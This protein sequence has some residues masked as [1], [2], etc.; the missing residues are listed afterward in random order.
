M[1]RGQI[2][3]EHFA[4]LNN[5]SGPERD[6]NV[7]SERR[8]A[9]FSRARCDHSKRNRRACTKL[10]C[11]MLAVAAT[12]IVQPT[13]ALASGWIVV[14]PALTPHLPV[15]SPPHSTTGAIPPSPPGH[16]LLK[17]GVSV[18]L[19]LQSE[20]VKVDINGPV[21]RTYI[22]QVF[23]NDTDRNLAGTYLFPL[24]E[25]ATFSSFS[26]QIDGKPVEGK[27]LEAQDA[28]N[29]YE[30][31]AR[32]M[33]DPGLLE[34]ADYK[35]VRARV[36]PIPPH[37]TKK[38]E[39]EYTQALKAE[40]GLFKYNFPLKADHNSEPAEAINVDMKL[41][42]PQGLRT[43]W[44]PTYTINS[45]RESDNRATI[46][47]SGKNVLPD[48][49]FLLYYSTS[50]KEMTADLMVQ[51]RKD[52]NGYF[53]LSMA[54]PMQSKIST[55]KDIVLVADTSGS[56]GGE[57][58]EQCKRALNFIVN[59]LGKTDRFGIVQFNT[60]V[61]QFRSD[62]V[63]ANDENK[64]A[65]AS[66]INNL[67]ARGG[68]N[69]SGALANAGDLLKTQSERP[70]YV[71]LMTDGEPTVGETNEAQLVQQAH[72]N[73]DIRLFDFGV[74]YDVNTRLLNALAEDHHGTAQYVEPDESLETALSSFY[75]KVKNPVLTDVSIK[76]EGVEVKN[77][78]PKEV[79]DIF[80]GTQVLLIGEYKTSGDAK[81]RITGKLNGQSK[82]YVFP[83]SFPA[84]ESGHSYLARLWAMRRI[85]YLTD[86][87]KSNGENREVI[88]EIVALSKKYGIISQYTSFLATDPAEGH[89]AARLV[90][91]VP[92]SAMMVSPVLPGNST[93]AMGAPDRAMA[94]ASADVDFGPYMAGLQR[95]IK[96]VW[97]P[98]KG[99]ES[100]QVV[101][102]FKLDRAGHVSD[103]RITRSSGVNIADQAA[104]RAVR[105]SVLRP[106]PSEASSPVDIQFTFDYNILSGRS[107][108]RAPAA[109]PVGKDAVL[110]AKDTT[111]LKNK[112]DIASAE[113]TPTTMRAVE[114][115]TFYLVD[116][117][118]TDSEYKKDEKLEQI[119]F[120]SEHYFNLVASDAQ[121]RKYFA[122]APQVIVVYKGHC[123]R[124]SATSA[125]ESA[126]HD[127]KA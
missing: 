16:P 33:I 59:S 64:K 101:V 41:A 34:Y 24:G 74:G 32:Q 77:V 96:H 43:I 68:T 2:Q 25:D 53:L 56:M 17:A 12:Y 80:A 105:D 60:D 62:L 48:K 78:Y 44:S 81:V 42:S 19:H 51:K 102:T 65:A 5:I 72:W 28:R 57:K 21:A 117:Y 121:L 119:D 35:T 70:A 89:G 49:D 109:S 13:S 50:D 111:L 11:L 126:A 14:D 8:L 87:A 85:G 36:F 58:I 115:K 125:I 10:A 112:E 90:S 107:S 91:R 1:V 22:T 47:Y 20:S 9:E 104:L 18:G 110:D 120:G 106:L 99:N 92:R 15:V 4:M 95:S 75:S 23:S 7:Q 76:Y 45:N 52:E 30:S 27:I 79:K 63:L 123:Y 67:E 6:E 82:E 3:L 54:P 37:G 98:P 116:G 71:I 108:G 40:N 39:L 97:M 83:V 61:E 100:K 113:E 73:R 69:I 124:I 94:S 31:I 118:W 46:S 55:P 122:V 127:K 66:F 114:D 103:E 29:Q 93:P 38:V 26:L 84:E 88:D 86:V